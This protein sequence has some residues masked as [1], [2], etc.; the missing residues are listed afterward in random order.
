M[1]YVLDTNVLLDFLMDREQKKHV[2]CVRLMERVWAGEIKIVLLSVVIAEIAWVMKSF[3]GVDKKEMVD[4]LKTLTEIKGCQVVERYEWDDIFSNY[5]EKKVKF[6]D[7]MI[8]G[9]KQIRSNK[10]TVIT[11]DKDFDKLGVLN[12][13]PGMVGRRIENS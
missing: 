11:F 5:K 4:A 9:V 8:A 3:Y 10:W 1:R 6:V 12:L 13:E 2:D 7:S